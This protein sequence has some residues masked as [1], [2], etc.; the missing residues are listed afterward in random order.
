SGTQHQPVVAR[1]IGNDYVIA[2]ADQSAGNSNIHARVYGLNSAH[3]E[4]VINIETAGDQTTPDVTVLTDGRFVISW[5]NG[6]K[7]KARIYDA[8]TSAINVTGTLGNDKYV[9]TGFAGDILFGDTG[10]DILA[11]GGGGDTIDGG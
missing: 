10:D 4:M 2:W 7:V 1:L 9:G 11:G 3:P 6:D 8:R 5:L